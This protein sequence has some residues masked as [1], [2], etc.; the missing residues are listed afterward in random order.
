MRRRQPAES[1]GL[2]ERPRARWEAM[3]APSFMWDD[4]EALRVARAVYRPAY[5]LEGFGWQ[6]D[7]HVVRRFRRDVVAAV[8][9]RCGELSPVERERS[10][11][12]PAF[13]PHAGAP[14]SWLTDV[15]V[16]GVVEG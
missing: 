11:R 14:R 3:G 4:A 2:F 13:A 1:F 15:R 9:E 7:R 12:Y 6:G 10:E 16:R 8:L 5:R